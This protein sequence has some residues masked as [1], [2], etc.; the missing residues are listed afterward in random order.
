MPQTYMLAKIRNIRLNVKVKKLFGNNFIANVQ[1]SGI[2]ILFYSSNQMVLCKQC[3]Q[4][5]LT[6]S[7]K[8]TFM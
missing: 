7:F 4:P 2:I 1:L 3:V 8:G 5:I 6:K